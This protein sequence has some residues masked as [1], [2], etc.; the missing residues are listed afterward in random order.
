M[1]KDYRR[2]ARFI[3]LLFLAVLF[4]LLSAQQEK[5]LQPFQKKLSYIYESESTAV[6]AGEAFTKQKEKKQTLSA[7]WWKNKG[8][9]TV[10]NQNLGS[11]ARAEILAVCGKTDL[12]FS[13]AAVLDYD[14]DSSCIIGSRT[15]SM[16]FGDANAVGLK[17]QYGGK[18]YAVANVLEN[19]KDVFLY[20]AGR[21]EN[22]LFNRVTF[23]LDDPANQAII[24]N[25]ANA[26]FA[27]DTFL[28]YTLF[29]FLAQLVLLSIPAFIAVKLLRM[30]WINGREPQTVQREKVF[31]WAAFCIAL[32]VFIKLAAAYLELPSDLIP[33][34]WSD[35]QFW[36]KLWEE[37]KANTAVFAETGLSSSDWLFF[38]PFTKMIVY[39]II[40][41]LCLMHIRKETFNGENYIT[42]AWKGLQRR[43]R[44]CKGFQS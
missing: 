31:W 11:L 7:V 43:R 5:H 36:T 26:A 12:L 34:K 18:D 8:K 13:D 37:K 27:P 42:Q 17:V 4:F 20:E 21:E 35:F 1:K 38:I 41:F 10:E 9:E 33:A 40:G 29:V 3:F 22:L 14:Q 39:G 16:L 2:Q 30:F 32:L 23:R 6:Q 28:D 15:A 19:S 24:K 44:G 25:K